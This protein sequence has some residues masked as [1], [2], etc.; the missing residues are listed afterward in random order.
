ME[1][2]LC[3]S[4]CSVDEPCG[5]MVDGATHKAGLQLSRHLIITCYTVEW[6]Y[7][8]VC[9]YCRCTYETDRRYCVHCVVQ[10]VSLPIKIVLAYTAI[11]IY[12][13]KQ[14]LGGYSYAAHIVVVSVSTK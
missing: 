6:M 3:R 13:H 7:T 11:Y 1:S 9:K 5:A 14:C 8:Y 10:T 12:I 2:V 4:S